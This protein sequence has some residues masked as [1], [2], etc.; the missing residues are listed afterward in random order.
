[1]WDE[2]LT[3]VEVFNIES[4]AQRRG[5]ALLRARAFFKLI[6]I[7]ST[8]KRL[9]AVG[10]QGITSVLDTS[11]W[12]EEES[13]SWHEGPSLSTGRS[14]FGALIAVPKLVCIQQNTTAH[15]CP[16]AE[17]AAHT[18]TFLPNTAGTL[19]TSFKL[20]HY[21]CYMY[22]RLSPSLCEQRRSLHVPDICP[23]PQ[24]NLRPRKVP[25]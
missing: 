11:E 23:F 2:V 16:S 7:G 10:G 9:L 22:R 4:K 3:S 25:A 8:Q 24:C 15:S 18:C 21:M 20:R 17:D 12:W 14:N 13:N 19:M 1:M 6:P 5:G